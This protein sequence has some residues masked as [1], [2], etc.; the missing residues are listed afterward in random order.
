MDIEWTLSNIPDE[1]TV[2][3]RLDD[4]D[5]GT[6]R[7]LGSF[8]SEEAVYDA[9]DEQF[10][11]YVGRI[12]LFT[13]IEEHVRPQPF[14]GATE[15]HR[16][17]VDEVVGAFAANGHTADATIA[18]PGGVSHISRMGFKLELSA[19]D[20][21]FTCYFTPDEPTIVSPDDTYDRPDA[22]ANT[23]D[24]LADRVREEQGLCHD[25]MFV[26]GET[27]VPRRGARHKNTRLYGRVVPE[28]PS[29]DLAT[30]QA[31]QRHDRVADA[32][33]NPDTHPPRIS[34]IRE[35]G[36]LHFIPDEDYD[37]I[38]AVDCP[39]DPVR[40]TDVEEYDFRTMS[41][42]AFDRDDV[43]DIGAEIVDDVA[44]DTDLSL[45]LV[46]VGTHNPGIPDI[47]ELPLLA[48]DVSD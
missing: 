48:V 8:S 11:S 28:Q 23:F 38:V 6:V 7:L 27:Y 9:L 45:S 17:A 42:T 35:N 29:S 41:S 13:Q 43:I 14:E 36:E 25:V 34:W 5:K 24:A 31:F 22:L 10:D 18:T 4:A 21:D 15:A 2:Y 44:S 12:T 46:N 16:A 40:A 32:L 19:R 3:A 33:F 26:G 39:R 20:Y 30:L 37:I 47:G 1:T